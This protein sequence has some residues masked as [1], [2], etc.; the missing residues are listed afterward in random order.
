MLMEFTVNNRVTML[1]GV[2]ILT[3]EGELD[4]CSTMKVGCCVN[5]QGDVKEMSASELRHC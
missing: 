1:T 5:F 4:C 3:M 2:M